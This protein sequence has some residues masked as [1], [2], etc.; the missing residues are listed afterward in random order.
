MPPLAP[1]TGLAVEVAPP[2]APRLAKA[3]LPSRRDIDRAVTGDLRECTGE[4]KC[5]AAIGKK[6]GVDVMVTGSVGALGSNYVLNIKAVDVATATQIR[7]M[8][9]YMALTPG[10]KMTDIPIDVVFI[11][12]CTNS[13]IED[14][15]AAAAIL[16]GQH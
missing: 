9:D 16:R 6:L 1:P 4:A 8:L 15:R 2:S 14:M 7:R 12:S 13:R 5:L 3:P 10:Q 11:G